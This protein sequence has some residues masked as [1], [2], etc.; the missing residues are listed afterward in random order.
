M[1]QA[2]T[3][4][5]VQPEQHDNSHLSEYSWLSSMGRDNQKH[6]A[7]KCSV[8][9]CTKCKTYLTYKAGKMTPVFQAINILKLSFIYTLLKKS[10]YHRQKKIIKADTEKTCRK[11]MRWTRSWFKNSQ[12]SKSIK[13]KGCYWQTLQNS[14]VFKVPF[15]WNHSIILWN[16][17]QCEFH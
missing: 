9:V 16:S 4:L 14:M 6:L 17:W 12:I 11:S 1:T 13:L 3:G 5:S 10:M 15:N 8:I 2:S 7:S